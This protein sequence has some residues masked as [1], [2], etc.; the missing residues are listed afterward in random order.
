MHQVAGGALRPVR[1]VGAWQLSALLGIAGPDGPEA[2]HPDLLLALWPGEPG[3][4]D[5][6]G[7]ATLVPAPRPDL[8]ATPSSDHHHW[9]AIDAAALALALREGRGRCGVLLSG[10]NAAAEHLEE[11]ARRA[12]ALAEQSSAGSRMPGLT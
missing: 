12:R 4:W 8:A 3:A 11:A 1:E 6:A 7:L 10:G 2:E 9:P 5:P